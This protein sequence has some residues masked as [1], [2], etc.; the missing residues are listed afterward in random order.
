MARPIC[1]R[2]PSIANPRLH[3][4]R[5]LSSASFQRRWHDVLRDFR[6]TGT[7]ACVLP[8]THFA[9]RLTLHRTPDYSPNMPCASRFSFKSHFPNFRFSCPSGQGVLRLDHSLYVFCTVS[10][11]RV[12]SFCAINEHVCPTKPRLFDGENSRATELEWAWPNSLHPIPPPQLS[13][14][15]RLLRPESRISSRYTPPNRIPRNPFKTNDG[16]TF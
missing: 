8:L 14:F 2:S 15:L 10:V 12:A 9:S 13:P 6:G 11:L 5:S 4:I 16:G 7:P 3:Q 1:S